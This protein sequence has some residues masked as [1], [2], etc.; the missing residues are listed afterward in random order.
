MNIIPV[1]THQDLNEFIRLP[2]QLFKTDDHW[3]PPLIYDQKNIF[4]PNKNNLLQ[5]CEYQL[6]ILRE[7]DEIIGRIAVYINRN[8][9]SYWEETTGFFGHYECVDQQDASRIL[10]ETAQTWLQD[11]GMTTMRGPWNF[12]SQDFGIIIDGFELP[13]VI[14]SSYNPKYYVDQMS[15][16][17]LSKIKDLLV[18]NC[19]VSKGYQIPRRFLDFTDKIAKRYRVNVRPINMKNLVD[20]ARVIVKLTNESLA[21][22][23]GFYPIELKEAEQIAADLKQI[24]HPEVVL[25][26]EVDGLAIGYVITLPDV[27]TILKTMNGRLFP[28]GLFKLMS[29]LKKINRYRIWAMGIATAYQRKGIS[30]LLMRRLNDVL[31]PR[32]AYIEANY[33][34]ED[35]HLMKNAL[36]QL[37]FDLVKKYRVYDKHI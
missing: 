20:D 2:Y 23:W 14:L 30:V 1:N 33:V 36:V 21:N 11:R 16:F 4:N 18:Y 12:V 25:I 29:G 27:N 15:Q 37:Q 28:F 34:L 32:N 6:L 19:D 10:L 31:I 8:Y 17:G 13:P 7:R 9:N 35:N 5:H 26:A 24:I 22:N 3:I